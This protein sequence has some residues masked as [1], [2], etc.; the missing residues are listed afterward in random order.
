M[1]PG[2]DAVYAC[3]PPGSARACD[4]CLARAWLIGE[5]GGH[6]ET[7]RGRVAQVLALEDEQLIAAVGHDRTELLRAGLAEFDPGKARERSAAVG[8]EPICRCDPGYPRG[9]RALDAPPRVLHVAGGL[10]R[11]LTLV[12]DEPVAIVGARSASPYGIDV[13][14]SLGRGIAG[15]GLAVISGMALGIDSAAHDGA[16]AAHGPTIAVLPC[17]ADIAYPQ[18]KRGLH[19]QIRRT[20]SLVSELPPGTHAWR[21]TFPARNRIIAGLAAM[22]IVVEAGERSGALLTAGFAR[23]L[24]RPIG[25]VPGRITSPLSRGPNALLAGGASVVRSPQD[26][27]DHLFGVGVRRADAARQPDLAPELRVLLAAIADGY[28]T[29]VALERA[30]FAP[31]QGL[32]AL[33]SLELAGYVRREPGGRFAVRA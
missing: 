3:G 17:G 11:F 32:A 24:G 7:A 1:N 23:S 19:G 31:Q 30:G 22:T 29:G 13:A 20:G 8:L 26:V 12:A 15:A 16:I 28:E 21:W 33:A 25:A 5:L 18:R 2:G 4:R 27:L 10:D 14:R 9:L 6:L